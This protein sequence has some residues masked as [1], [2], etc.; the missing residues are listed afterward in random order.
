MNIYTKNFGFNY[1]N[2]PQNIAYSSAVILFEQLLEYG[3][4]TVWNG[5]HT[6][7]AFAALFNEDCLKK[8]KN[9]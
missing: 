1:H 7:Q 9:D 3:C 6:A 5:H 4:G 2:H 8:E